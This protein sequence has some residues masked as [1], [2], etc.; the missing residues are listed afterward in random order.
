MYAHCGIRYAEFGG[1]R[2]KLEVAHANSAPQVRGKADLAGNSVPGYMTLID[3]ETAFFEAAGMPPL[4]F[5]PTK[6]K[7]PACA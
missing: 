2:W 7:P 5:R 6:D 4:E 3:E 1:R